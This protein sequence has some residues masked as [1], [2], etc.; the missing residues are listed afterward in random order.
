MK[1][2]KKNTIKTAKKLGA[3][4]IVQSKGGLRIRSSIKAGL[5]VK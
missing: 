4:T 1:N 2:A 3:A 5:W